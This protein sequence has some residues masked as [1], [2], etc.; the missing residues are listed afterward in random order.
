MEEIG[1]LLVEGGEIGAK[2]AEGFEAIWG[3]E[4]AGDLL[5]DLG[6]THVVFGGIVGEG[7]V[8]IGHET[9]D[10]VGMSSQSVDEIER[11]VL[12][13]AAAL[14][15]GRSARIDG[16]AL[17]KNGLV[18]ASV[19]CAALSAAPAPATSWQAPTNRSIRRLA[20]AWFI[21][22]KTSVSSRR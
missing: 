11:L 19:V 1:T 5:L 13:G 8:V 17:D 18:G 7:D 15:G 6:H 21:S 4:A 16:G 10:I 12:L 20:Q 22:S 3:A 9:P 14:A 2:G